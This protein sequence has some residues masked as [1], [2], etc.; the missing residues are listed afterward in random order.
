MREFQHCRYDTPP[1]TYSALSGFDFITPDY[2][3][4][5]ENQTLIGHLTTFLKRKMLP[6]GMFELFRFS[7]KILIVYDS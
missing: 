4:L 7:N 6:N 1:N 3:S 5:H 2:I